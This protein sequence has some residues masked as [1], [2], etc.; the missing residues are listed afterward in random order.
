MFGGW[1]AALVVSLASRTVSRTGLL[2][3]VVK[4][5]YFAAK[6]LTVG[7]AATSSPSM[8]GVGLGFTRQGVFGL[9]ILVL[10]ER[11]P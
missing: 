4:L 11:V 6:D 8:S 2:L 3:C 9:N 7:L 5:T 1:K 10:E